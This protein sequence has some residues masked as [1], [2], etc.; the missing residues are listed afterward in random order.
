[1]KT[2][3]EFKLICEGRYGNEHAYRKIWNELRFNKNWKKAAEL[4]DAGKEDEAKKLIAS[5]SAS[6]RSRIDAARKNPKDPLNFGSAKTTEF[7]GGKTAGD[8]Q[9]YYDNL[10][11]VIDTVVNSP[12][13][14]KLRGAIKSKVLLGKRMRGTG[15]GTAELTPQAKGAGAKS[16]T[17][18]ADN[19]IVDPRNKRYRQG[20]SN[21]E[22]DAQIATTEPGD[23]RSAGQAASKR[24]A[25]TQVVQSTPRKERGESD[26]DYRERVRQSKLN[27]RQK[28][29]EIEKDINTSTSRIADYGEKQRVPQDQEAGN[30]DL[31]SKAQQEIDRL[32]TRYPGYRGHLTRSLASGQGRFAGTANK[33]RNAPGTAS[34][35]VQT[36]AV[37]KVGKQGFHTGQIRN[38]TPI[39]GR[40]SQGR[41]ATKPV[42]G[43]RIKRPGT[44]R[45][46]IKAPSTTQTSSPRQTTFADFQRRIASLPPQNRA[47][48]IR[49]AQIKAAREGQQLR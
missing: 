40:A 16:G 29:K 34:I 35:A 11:A 33:D 23:A 43:P 20:I 36:P 9:S 4:M 12:K 37:G 7:T 6:V 26:S 48:A 5:L 15:T 13:E 46:D 42:S 19:E 3:Q 24:Y 47:Q 49:N 27:Q 21:K 45:Y 10:D 41:G 8:E 25:R 30:K 39:K 14:K 31:V 2:F 1:M 44:V 18:K 28:R 32:D 38:M 22:G 17:S